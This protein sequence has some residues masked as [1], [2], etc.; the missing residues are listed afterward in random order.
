MIENPIIFHHSRIW[1]D[2]YRSDK[3]VFGHFC[4]EKT[5]GNIDIHEAL[6][7]W[8]INDARWEDDIEPLAEQRAKAAVLR[9]RLGEQ[10]YEK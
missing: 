3:F 9:K 6:K 8:F 10:K 7:D 4:V 2:V 1:Q 5:D